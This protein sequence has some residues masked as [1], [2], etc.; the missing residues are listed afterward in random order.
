MTAAIITDTWSTMPTA[1]MI[2]SSE[3]TM[4][5]RMICTMIAAKLAF[6]LVRRVA[7][8]TFGELVDLLGRL[9]HEE[10]AAER[11]G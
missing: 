2:E 5:M 8:L 11:S 3:N 7:F 10:Q 6:T 9:P 1:V 4:S